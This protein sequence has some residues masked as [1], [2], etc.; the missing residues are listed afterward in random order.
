MVSHVHIVP[1]M[2]WDREWYFTAEESQLLLLNNMDEI[3]TM[4]E[5]NPKYPCYVLDGQ[6]AI[7]DDYFS[8]KP[9]QKERFQKL[10]E[11]GKLRIGPWFTQ[12]DTMVVRGESITRNLLLGF[13][14]CK[15]FGSIMKI[16]YLPDSFGQS[17]QIPMILN[18]FGI[19]RS[20][21][22]R[23]TSERLGT[24]KTEFIHKSKDGSTVT[25]QVLP[26]GYAIGK[27][28]PED[29][30]E[31]SKRMEKYLPVLDKGTTTGHILLPNGHDQMPVQKNIFQVIRTLENLYPNRKFILSDYESVFDQIDTENLDII[32]GEFLDG[33]YMRVHRS[34]YSSR[35]DIKTMNTR[36]ENKLTN[37]LEPLATIAHSLG[38]EYFN[39]FI[40]NIWKLLLKNHA[41]D[42]IGCCCS[43]KVMREIKIRFEL[44][45]EKIDRMI[46][47]YKRKISDA[48]PCDKGLDK[49]V[50]FNSL[51][52]SREAVVRTQVI[53]R[54]KDFCLVDDNQKEYNYQIIRSE[55]IDP[56]LVDR[57][58]VH[59]GNYDPFICYTIEFYANIPAMGYKAF[60]IQ[61]GKHT[62]GKKSKC[63]NLQNEFYNIE[64]QSNGCLTIE[65]K[66]T[67]RVYKDVLMLE[68]GADGG[69]SY[70]YSPIEKDWV[71]TSKNIQ[72]EVKTIEFEHSQEAEVSIVMPI[73]KDLDE[74]EKKETSSSLKVTYHLTLKKNDRHIEFKFKVNNQAK[75]HRVRLYIPQ[76]IAS[77]YAVADNQ[78]G[79][80]YRKLKDLA[81]KCWKEEKW[82][83][84]PDSIYPMLSYVKMDQDRLTFITNSVR[85]YE[86]VNDTIMAITLF[87]ATGYLGL[88][89]L[90]RRPGRPS[91]IKMITKD[92][93]MLGYQTYEF[94]LACTENNTAAQIAKEY[95][96]PMITYNKMP[97]NAMKMNEVSFKT[98]Y[99]Y[100]LLK[101]EHPSF[102]V[103]ALKQAE[104]KNGY[105]L[106][107]YN[108]S[109]KSICIQIESKYKV[110]E[111]DLKEDPVTP[112]NEIY[113][114]QVRTYRLT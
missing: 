47:Y 49:V 26:L 103:T 92:H 58:I 77:S 69:D 37:V 83:E 81:M 41:H 62:N 111:T 53:T 43:D 114:S 60:L 35:A 61:S 64:I 89:N 108:A 99:S 102:I 88:E 68:D 32:E 113:S 106:R 87:R 36:L 8:V 30:K 105:I 57:Q 34:I 72:A 18:G 107:G 75:N 40:E 1:H 33:K 10:V 20:I 84:R 91:G 66:E 19:T 15:T 90:I 63:T 98:P 74:R 14:D 48:I 93:Q 6:T 73:P 86:A 17:A 82:V 2:H 95:L 12:T 24:N 29:T 23:G 85:E 39:G 28:L 52:Y 109:N 25:C 56:G 112:S 70:D 16:G 59:Y 71:L 7:L 67:G 13:K 44:A 96:T 11:D 50:V 65:D 38:F 46:D 104:D 76:C 78:F 22:W 42:S 21:F 54:M 79:Q 110:L 97:Y 31:L 100:S 55:E 101:L 9:D 51:P 80:I 4:L 94:A 27:Y 3:F 45:E 5:N